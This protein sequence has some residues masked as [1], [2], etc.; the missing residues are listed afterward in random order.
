VL[1]SATKFL[2]GHG[3]VMGGIVACDEQFARALRQV[4]IATG[5]LPPG[6]QCPV[7]KIS[8]TSRTA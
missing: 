2:G 1:H 5:G 7:K 4:R 6:N 8:R 3:D